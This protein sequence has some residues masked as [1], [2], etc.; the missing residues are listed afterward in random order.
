MARWPGA[1]GDDGDDLVLC[2]SLSQARTVDI[3]MMAKAAGFDAVY[4]D[5]EHTA[6]SLET[7]AMLC[8]ASIGFGL[9]PL[10]RV[11]SHDHL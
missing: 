10:V 8:A 7:A 5:L 3:P 1:G 11:P 9:V 4:I 6:T 2:L